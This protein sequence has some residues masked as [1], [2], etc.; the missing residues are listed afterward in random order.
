MRNAKYLVVLGAVALTVPGCISPPNDLM[1]K[2]SQAQDDAKTVNA[3]LYSPDEMKA[4]TTAYEAA[5]AEVQAQD[6]KFIL[7]R[8]YNAATSQLNEAVEALN[9]AKVDALRKKA[10]L[11]QPVRDDMRSANDVIDAAE[12][13]FAKATAH[14]AHVDLT[15]WQNRLAELRQLQADAITAQNHD[16]L[17]TAKAK[18]DSAVTGATELQ[19]TMDDQLGVK[20]RAKP[21]AAESSQ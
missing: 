5:Q 9:K 15:A 14:K 4:A 20:K 1:T 10:S 6:K 19:N 16:D 13:T 17:I 18:L 12:Q 11:K 8:N 21:A 7:L 3:A 2:A